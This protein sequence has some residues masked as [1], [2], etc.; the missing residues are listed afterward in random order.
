MASAIFPLQALQPVRHSAPVGSLNLAP[1]RFRVHKP[2]TRASR[3]MV[4]NCRTVNG[5]SPPSRRCWA[6]GGPYGHVPRIRVEPHGLQNFEYKTITIDQT[7]VTRGA[8]RLGHVSSYNLLI[9]M[10]RVN[11]V[12]VRRQPIQLKYVIATSMLSLPRQPAT[13]DADVSMCHVSPFSV[14]T[15]VTSQL[16]QTYVENAKNA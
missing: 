10:T 3:K 2:S 9:N 8:L 16:V 12:F 14:V 6:H 4:P 13:Q 11:P 7:R 15:R 1:E 5:I